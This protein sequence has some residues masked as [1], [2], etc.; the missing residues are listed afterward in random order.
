MNRVGKNGRRP[1]RCRLRPGKRHAPV[2]QLWS[3]P[4]IM[5]MISTTYRIAAPVNLPNRNIRVTDLCIR[6]EIPKSIASCEREVIFVRIRHARRH[7]SRLKR[8]SAPFS[9]IWT[10]NF[11]PSGRHS[12]PDELA[13]GCVLVCDQRRI[14]VQLG[15][16]RRVLVKLIG[17]LD[18]RDR[19]EQLDRR[20]ALLPFAARCS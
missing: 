7:S 20:R 16:R 15:R 4:V 11:E 8:L 18:R 3:R 2:A 14:G 13:A 1:R 5:K 12:N 10:V 6:Q 19:P 9:P 17:R